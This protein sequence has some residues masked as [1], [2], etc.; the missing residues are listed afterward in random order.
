MKTDDVKAFWA[1]KRRFLSTMILCCGRTAPGRKPTSALIWIRQWTLL[2]LQLL[3][4]HGP[5]KTSFS[6]LLPSTQYTTC[7]V[8]VADIGIAGPPYRQSL[9]VEDQPRLWRLGDGGG[10]LVIGMRMMADGGRGRE[11]HHQLESHP[12]A[13]KNGTRLADDGS[14]P[15]PLPFFSYILFTTEE[16][17]W[18]LRYLC[19]QSCSN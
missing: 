5:I 17:H 10:S 12:S 1:W 13:V 8:V 7:A 19:V 15:V 3:Y 9:Y 4:I 14:D 18:R 11:S 6:L 16:N 2:H